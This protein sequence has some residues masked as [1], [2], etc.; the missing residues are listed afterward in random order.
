MLPLPGWGSYPLLGGKPSEAPSKPRIFILS[1]PHG[2]PIE[3]TKDTLLKLCDK[4]DVVVD[5]GNE[6][7]ERTERRQKVSQ[8][9]AVM[10]VGERGGGVFLSSEEEGGRGRAD[11]GLDHESPSEESAPVISPLNSDA[12]PAA[13]AN[14]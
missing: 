4:G 9:R 6:W 13:T 8:G 14:A 12:P 1:L 10:G 7:W 5:A 3:E 11:A 2:P